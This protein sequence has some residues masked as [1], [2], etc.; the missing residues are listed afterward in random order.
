MKSHELLC[1]FS[2]I[3]IAPH[4]PASFAIGFSIV[5][6]LCSIIAALMEMRK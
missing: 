5:V 6:L 3:Y 1:L 4:L 2:A